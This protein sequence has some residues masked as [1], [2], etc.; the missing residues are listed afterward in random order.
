[1][2]EFYRIKRLPPYV[3]AIVDKLKLEARRRGDDIIDMGMGNPD[4][5]TPEHIVDK[6]V[7]KAQ[8]P[9]QPP[10]LR[11]GRH[12]QAAGGHLRLV[13]APLRR[14]VRPRHRGGGD[15]RRQGGPVAPGPGDHRPGRPGPGADPDLPDPPL[16]RHHRRR[17][18]PLGAGQLPRRRVPRPARGGGALLL[19]AA[20]G[21]HR[22]YPHNPTTATV[23]LAF[24]ERL[25]AFAKENELIVIHDFAYAD[26]VFDGYVAPSMLQVPG[27][28]DVGV[29]F[30]TLSKSYNM[31]GWRVG[32]CVGNPRMVNALQADQELP[33]LRHVPADPDRRDHRPERPTGVRRRDRRGLPEAARRAVRR[34]QPGRLGGREAEGDDVRLGAH[35]RGVPGP[36]ARSSSPSSC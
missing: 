1:M 7:E 31:A 5:P 22:L 9:A 30:F 19:A 13:P 6:L 35:P 4:G 8:R 15:H 21:D 28:S 34:A 3:F 18:R 17:R 26:L 29:E 10:L 23:D 16:L 25:V 36:W 12:P 32:F 24:F 2:E 20:E 33:R 11:L 14:R 27:A